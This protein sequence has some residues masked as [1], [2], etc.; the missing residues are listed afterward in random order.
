MQVKGKRHWRTICSGEDPT[1]QGDGL[2]KAE[3][4]HPSGGNGSRHRPSR[5]GVLLAVPGSKIRPVRRRRWLDLERERKKTYL[6]PST[7]RHWRRTSPWKKAAAEERSGEQRETDMSA[8]RRKG[9]HC[10]YSCRKTPIFF[11]AEAFARIQLNTALPRWTFPPPTDC[12][13]ECAKEDWHLG[14]WEEN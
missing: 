9:P 11:A 13:M 4:P 8:W 12:S 14:V 2:F 1:K 10:R 3:L 5:G 6:R 7:S